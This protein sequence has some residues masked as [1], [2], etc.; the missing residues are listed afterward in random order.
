MASITSKYFVLT[1]AGDNLNFL[2]FDLSYGTINM[3]GQ[4]IAYIGSSRVDAIFVSPGLTYDLT[5]TSGG[6]ADKIYLTGSLSDYTLSLFG[7]SN[8]NLKLTGV[9]NGLSE[10]VIVPGGTALNYESLIFANGTV[11][12]N[13]LYNSFK[14]TTTAP[15]PTGE[16]SLAPTAPSAAA[17]GATLDATIKAFSANPAA[18]GQEGETFAT[19]KPGIK[20]IVSGGSGVDTV[21]VAD[22]ANVTFTITGASV[23]MIYMRGYWSDYT[24]ELLANNTQIKFTRTLGDGTLES[25]IVSAGTSVN[26]DRVIF[27]DGNIS[28]ID[29]KTALLD[30]TRGLDVTVPELGDA[31]DPNLTTPGINLTF[32][33]HDNGANAT[34]T[35]DGITS[36]ITTT[37]QVEGVDAGATW[38]YSTDG[39]ASWSA[40]QAS[41]VK[42]FAL[43]EGIYAVNDIQVVQSSGGVYNDVVKNTTTYTVDA[44]VPTVTF[45]APEASYG[46]NGIVP[47]TAT[48]NEPV[49]GSF[50]AKFNGVNVVFTAVA[51]SSTEFV[52]SY[53]HNSGLAADNVQVTDFVT[54]N[55]M[56]AAG[57]KMANIIT[58]NLSGVDLAAPIVA[59][60]LLSFNSTASGV[61]SDTVGSSI[62]ITALFSGPLTTGAG[63]ARSQM[64]LELDSGG[65]VLLSSLDATGTILSGTYLVSAGENSLD[66]NVVSIS[67][68][69]IK[70]RDDFGNTQTITTFALPATNLAES[71][72]IIVDTTAPDAPVF[73]GVV[74]TNSGA[75]DTYTNDNTPTITGTAE[76]GTTIQLFQLDGTLIVTPTITTAADGSWSYTFPTLAD[77]SYPPIT[78]RATDAGGNVSAIGT[79]T[80]LHIEHTAPTILS[81]A[82]TDSSPTVVSYTAGQIITITATTSEGMRAGSSITA[83]LSNG[84]TVDLYVNES[85]TTMIGHYTVPASATGHAELTVTGFTVPVGATDSAG[86]ALVAASFTGTGNLT[87]V[88]IASTSSYYAISSLLPELTEGAPATLTFTITRSGNINDVNAAN[89]AWS[90]SGAAGNAS[91]VTSALSGIETFNAGQTSKTISITL[92][93]DTTPEQLENLVATISTTSANS[94]IVTPSASIDVLDNDQIMVGFSEIT[95]SVSETNTANNVLNLVVNRS[96]GDGQTTTVNYVVQGITADGNDVVLGTGSIIMTTATQNI[97]VNIKDDLIAEGVETFKVVITGATSTGGVVTNI[98]SGFD[99]N[100]VSIIDNDAVTYSLNALEVTD[101]ITVTEGDADKILAITVTRTDATAAGTASYTISGVT[102]DG[103]DVNVG[104]GTVTF[105]VGAL[106]AEI[107]ALIKGDTLPEGTETFNV[108]LTGATETGKAAMVDIANS[109]VTVS[110]TDNDAVSYSLDAALVASGISVTEGNVGDQTL[111]ITVYR[112]SAA[113]VGTASFSISG[114]TA[115]A[116]DVGLVATDTVTFAAGAFEATINVIIKGDTLKEETETFKVSL[117]DATAGAASAFVDANASQVIVSI[118]DN[119][120]TQAHYAVVAEQATAYEAA[121]SVSYTIYRSGITSTAGSVD[122]KLDGTALRGVDYVNDVTNA[123]TYNADLGIGSISFDANQLSK[124]ITIMLKNDTIVDDAETLNVILTGADLGQG[125]IDTSTASTIILDTISTHYAITVDAASV[126]EGAGTVVYTVTRSG[127]TSNAG[128][129]DFALNGGATRGVDYADNVTGDDV[130]YNGNGLGSISFAANETTK[131]I[132]VAITDD[133]IAEAA[134]TLGITLNNANNGT[135]VI[136]TASASVSIIDNDTVRYSVQADS[137]AISESANS[138]SYII[139]RSGDSSAAGSVNF[140]LFGSAGRVASA[141]DF[142]L[143]SGLTDYAY[144]DGATSY[145]SVTNAGVVNFAAG[146]TSKTITFALADDSVVEAA[147]N[148]SMLIT[149]ANATDIID[150]ATA[151]VTISDNETTYYAVTATLDNVNE[152]AGTVYFTFTRSGAKDT[153]GTVDYSLS[154]SALG[155]LKPVSGTAFGSGIDYQYDAASGTISF[156]AG[157]TSKTIA[158]NLNDDSV[159]ESDET[160]TVYLANPVTSGASS[161]ISGGSATVTITD[162]D[163]VSYSIVAAQVGSVTEGD[164]KTISYIITRSGDVSSAGA[165]DFQLS[166]TATA[167]SDYSNSIKV[168]GVDLLDFNTASH[169]GTITFDAHEL[170]KVIT[171]TVI[172]DISMEVTENVQMLLSKNAS[173]SSSV[174]ETASAST[175]IADNDNMVWSIVTSSVNEDAGTIN[176]TITRTG[177]TTIA[178]NINFF[179]TAGGTATGGTH[180]GTDLSA[181]WSAYADYAAEAGVAVYFKAGDASQTVSVK[182]NNDQLSEGAETVVGA[183]SDAS[184]G[185]I[186]TATA[187]ATIND[188]D[189][190][191]WSVTGGQS[192]SEADGSMTFTVTRSGNLSVEGQIDFTTQ[193]GTATGHVGQAGAGIVGGLYNDVIDYTEVM[194]RLVFKAGQASQDIKIDVLQ[195]SNAEANETIGV[196]ISNAS[197]SGGVQSAINGGVAYN[198]ILDDDHNNWSLSAGTAFE[199]EGFVIYTVTRTGNLGSVGHVQFT[200]ADGSATVADG[201]YTAISGAAGLLTFGIDQASMEVRVAINNDG[202]AEGNETF[203]ASLSKA[204]VVAADANDIIISPAAVAVVFDDD[205]A[206][207]NISTASSGTSEG[208][209]AI[210]TVTRSGNK[211]GVATIQLTT[212]DGTAFEGVDFASGDQTLTFK[213]GETTQDVRILILTD[214]KVEGTSEDFQVSLVAGSQSSGVIDTNTVRPV[215]NP[216]GDTATQGAA[217]MNIWSVAAGAKYVYEQDSYATFTVTRTGD[218]TQA[219]AINFSTTGTADKGDDYVNADQ[220]LSFAVGEATQVVQVLL[221]SDALAEGMET[222]DAAITLA[223]GNTTDVVITSSASAT[224]VNSGEM[225]WGLNLNGFAQYESLGLIP[226]NITRTGD[227]SAATIDLITSSVNAGMAT[228]NVDYIPIDTSTATGSGMHI[229]FAAGETFKTIYVQT[230]DDLTIESYEDIF[231]S[232]SDPSSGTVVAQTNYG[233]GKFVARIHSDDDLNLSGAQGTSGDDI[234]NSSTSLITVELYGFAGNDILT[235]SA[236]AQNHLEGGAGADTMIGGVSNVDFVRYDGSLAGV[237]VDFLNAGNNHGGDA[238]GDV[239]VSIERFRGSNYD[240]VVIGGATQNWFAT[241]SGDDLIIMNGTQ[242]GRAVAGYGADTVYGA[243]GNDLIFGEEN[244]IFEEGGYSGWSGKTG[245]PGND[246]LS[247]GGGNDTIYGHGGADTLIGGAGNDSMSGGTGI[248][249]FVYTALDMTA[250]AGLG[251]DTITDFSLTDGEKLQFNNYFYAAAAITAANVGDYLRVTG[252]GASSVLEVDRDGGGAGF[253][254]TQIVQLTNGAFGSADLATMLNAGQLILATTPMPAGSPALT[255][256]SPAAAETSVLATNN[257]V[258]TFDK[259]MK[260]GTGDIVLTYTTASG[261]VSNNIAVTDSAQVTIDGNLIIIN[262]TD[263]LASGGTYAVTMASGVLLNALDN[264]AY[265]GLSAGMLDFTVSGS[266]VSGVITGTTAADTLYTGFAAD[267]VVAGDGN[268][269]IYGSAGADTI[270]GGLG[271]DTVRYDYSATAVTVN[272]LTNTGSAGDAAGDTYISIEQAYGSQA[273][274]TLTLGNL[275]NGA[276]YGF[277]GNDTLTG[278]TGNDVIRGGEGAD[279]MDGG[280]GID[281]IDYRD[282]TAAVNVDLLNN[283]V[284]GGYAAGDTIIN[285]ENVFGSAYNDIITGNANNNSIQGTGGNDTIAGGAGNDAL[286]GNT[287]AANTAGSD[288]FVYA[289]LDATAN[290]GL[291]LDTIYYFGTDGD[292]SLNLAVEDVLDMTGMFAAGDVNAGNI[293]QYL[294]MN[295]NTLQVDRDGAGAGYAFTNL[296]NFNSARDA[297]NT[298]ITITDSM[299]ANMLTAGQILVA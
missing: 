170:S 68:A 45:S 192:V 32:E 174:I 250:N 103:A 94:V 128:S 153:A 136:D 240:D 85:S 285:F 224:I 24:K 261:S 160:I 107:N 286:Y 237:H 34:S 116:S 187:T 105:A 197:A 211:T 168:D 29:A 231:Y 221:K 241:F 245:A 120:Q 25:V 126:D 223:A 73:T 97:A 44:S 124:T 88:A 284:S 154:G 77:G 210:V 173:F 101:G 158:F 290:G 130:I 281:I 296:I 5:G 79:S 91:D 141:A 52:G 87:N 222:I 232:I 299:L 69:S 216:S 209:Y 260:A 253:G 292:N 109:A 257:I 169:S 146:E 161:L 274:D 50:T 243:A 62:T 27:R 64:T 236:T 138:F 110:I 15:T 10:T 132:T 148:I 178:A 277:A 26:Y 127:Y 212:S 248:D 297:S 56:D 98:E 203:S 49:T 23:D 164:G 217:S 239:L 171:L 142:N 118:I 9:F 188:N 143:A 30:V 144:S 283:Q 218:L 238:E 43:A 61:H 177:D 106:T 39:G 28:T 13:A 180:I 204:A 226:I 78:A 147:E 228:T 86:N 213:D 113:T 279:S 90:L 176:Y 76:A 200:T 155:E 66:L 63:L 89:V 167:G 60:T 58:G 122:F 249:T 114:I 267:S 235:G 270:D 185:T 256:S 207:W 59:P 201:D 233:N 71:A 184:K 8:Q 186:A 40:A 99:T 219:A 206:H 294:H 55:L 278:G 234:L 112:S 181:G 282:S 263:Y 51:G 159:I 272:L 67:S 151:K 117:T 48:F 41:T 275:A 95:A 202:T 1:P 242:N 247:G 220:T 31:W 265:A 214:D 18:A 3:I 205:Q 21:Y 179:T 4:E 149:A 291:G 152:A 229:T 295:G 137:S 230:I 162:N 215:I 133:T 156:D 298:V 47:I 75:T 33:L 259:V 182:L 268:D 104:T 172:D 82:D 175:D 131:Y 20:F 189:M 96:N 287:A 100:I 17:P 38:Q 93:N 293:T 266:M 42:S 36:D 84:D 190:M 92:N 14:N 271:V 129:V 196:Q 157:E 199:N 191:Q 145:D 163:V 125:V 134:E 193:Y 54:T 102:A 165:V 183:I 225:V 166:G 108:T 280:A 258:L 254:W 252:A 269:V 139:T 140:E 115:D 111:V 195:D 289:A 83:T 37:V 72:D 53:V 46:F 74:G 194:Q 65:T 2:D 11:N 80:A 150:T 22:G 7:T 16:T 123:T 198:T 135:A 6:G 119:D 276:L 121:G 12:S 70:Y 251:L 57:N 255:S 81:F 19:T 35:D 244:S 264:A 288:T 246:Y 227:L 208:Q 262:P 273:G